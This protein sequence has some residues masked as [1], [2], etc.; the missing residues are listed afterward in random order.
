MYFIFEPT[1]ENLHLLRLARLSVASQHARTQM[2]AANELDMAKKN[3][4]IASTA[5]LKMLKGLLCGL[6]AG[7]T[8]TLKQYEHYRQ[9][10]GSLNAD[11]SELLN[12]FRQSH[13]IAPQ[14]LDDPIEM[15]SPSTA[16]ESLES[17]HPI[18]PMHQMPYTP[19]IRR[20]RLYNEAATSKKPKPL[21]KVLFDTKR[22]NQASAS[23][24]SSAQIS[25][26][27]ALR[28]STSCDN[29][30]QAAEQFKPD[31]T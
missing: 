25:G 15:Q 8:L 26:G 4:I 20:N 7:V 27:G 10:Y 24:A 29:L 17:E 14:M 23:Q 18:H 21:I 3:R 19:M 12:A 28:R 6:N 5:K 2:S 1:D 22:A 31:F 11:V 16:R 13:S 9:E 30:Q